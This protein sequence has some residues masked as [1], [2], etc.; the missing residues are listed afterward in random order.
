MIVVVI[1][2]VVVGGGGGGVWHFQ[3]LPFPSPN[4][5]RNQKV[6]SRIHHRTISGS[7]QNKIRKISGAKQ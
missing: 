2:V 4:I 7:K 1:V 5:A 3:F 6:L